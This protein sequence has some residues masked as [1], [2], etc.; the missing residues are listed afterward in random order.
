MI[1]SNSRPRPRPGPRT[2]FTLIEIM[3]A[4]TM[5]AVVL[6]SVARLAT[7]IAVRGRTNDLVA[8]RTAVL[9]LEANKFGA[10]PFNDLSG[11]STANKTLT[12]RGFAYTRRIAIT[13]AGTNRFTIKIVVVPTLD[14][15]KLDSVFVER[16]RPPSGTPLCTSC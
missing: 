15:T 14:P 1:P 13:A 8:K 16:T 2:G 4:M 12:A 3:V 11:W 7:M 9:Q 6:M 5:L 10:V